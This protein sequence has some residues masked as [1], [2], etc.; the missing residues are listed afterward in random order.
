MKRIVGWQKFTL[1]IKISI[2]FLLLLILGF[3]CSTTTTTKLPLPP[4]T[5]IPTVEIS[6]TASNGKNPVANNEPTMS[7]DIPSCDWPPEQV[8]P[9]GINSFFWSDDGKDLIFS[10]E[11]NGNLIKFDLEAKKLEELPNQQTLDQFRQPDENQEEI[12]SN[13]GISNYSEIFLSPDEKSVV[14]LKTVD[15]EKF[16]FLKSSDRANDI[17]LGKIY[18]VISAVY[19][20]N[21][22]DEL[23]ISIDWLSP[24]GI[25][26]AYVY[27][28]D[29]VNLAID[30]EI[31]NTPEYRNLTTIGVTPD[32]HWLMFVSYARQDRSVYLHDLS[33]KMDLKTGVPFPPLDLHWLSEDEFVAIGY[34]KDNTSHYNVAYF[35]YKYNIP[36][37]ELTLLLEN[38]INVHPFILDAASIAPS[39]KL[40][41]FIQAGNRALFMI[42]CE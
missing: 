15:E 5:S 4:S 40:M 20:I 37:D 42:K 17:P 22:D 18:G 32:D 27:R 35:V 39:G 10:M 33:T 6:A 1:I 3:A 11:N 30:I 26:D 12:A 25:G 31:P 24:L 29:L 13:F 23:L 2:A 16:V 9:E 14:F 19:W 38:S 7:Q 21:N 28:V 34:L 36:R 41:A 8:Y